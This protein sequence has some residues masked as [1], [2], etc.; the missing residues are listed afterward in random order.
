MLMFYFQVLVNDNP[1]SPSYPA[2]SYLSPSNAILPGQG[3]NPFGVPVLW[4]GRPLGSAF[5]SPNAPRDIDNLRFSLGL[6]GN[7][8]GF[9]WDLR[10]TH[11]ETDHYF[12]QPDTSTTRFSAAIAGQGGTTGTESWN[13][14][15]PSANSASLREWISTAQE[16]WSENELDVVD[17]VFSGE[18]GST[19]AGN[20]DI[21]FGLQ[22]REEAFDLKRD[23]GSIVEFDSEGNLV[24]PADLLFL[25]G[26]SEINASRDAIA[27]FAEV[28]VPVTDKL[29][30][31]GAVRY[32]GFE[33]D[34]TFDPKISLRYEVSDSLILRASA[35]TSFREASLSQLYSSGVGLQGIQDFTTDGTPKGGTT[36]IRIVSK[37]AILIYLQKSLIT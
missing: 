8:G 9:D 26:G 32:E 33:D 20:I 34:S 7:L 21:A 16:T 29:Q 28:S 27:L 3:G 14:F 36:F 1:Q 13:L 31:N 2:L 17:L 37:M 12:Y 23:K 30:V 4:L 6:T 11:S 15:D 25:G 5:P 35:S 10:Y 19:A 22:Y 24:K 18:I